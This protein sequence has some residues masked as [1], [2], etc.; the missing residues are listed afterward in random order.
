MSTI[1]SCSTSRWEVHLLEM[2]QALHELMLQAMHTI[3]LAFLNRW[4]MCQWQMP[5]GAME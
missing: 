4:S 5:G 1:T 3:M 2:P